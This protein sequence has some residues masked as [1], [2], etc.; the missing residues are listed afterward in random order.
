MGRE[1]W[2][3]I[4][5]QGMDEVSWLSVGAFMGDPAV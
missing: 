5:A 3:R 1:E 4:E 2:A